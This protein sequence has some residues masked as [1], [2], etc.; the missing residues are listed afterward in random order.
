MLSEYEDG[1]ASTR[2]F[3]TEVMPELR[4]LGADPLFDTE[5]AAPPAFQAA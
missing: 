4:K 3:A 2:L 1:R 5:A